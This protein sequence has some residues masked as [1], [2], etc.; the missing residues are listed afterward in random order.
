MSAG[1]F[2]ALALILWSALTLL[3]GEGHRNAAFALGA[4]CTGAFFAACRMSLGPEKMRHRFAILLVGL[5]TAN[6]AFVLLAN[7]PALL[8]GARILGWGITRQPI[9]G[10]SVMA[11][12]YLTA[13][14]LGLSGK[15]RYFGAAAI[16]GAFILAMQS[17]G[18]LVG[19]AGGTLVLL[20]AQP[21]R[22]RA[23]GSIAAMAGLCTLLPYRWRQQGQ[24]MLFARGSSHR[25]EIWAQS[26][27]QIRERPLFGHGLAA[28]LPPAPTGFPH[29]LYLS[30]LFYSGA[31]G[32]LLFAGLAAIVTIRI[33]RGMAEADRAWVAAL[34]ANALLAGLTD[35][36]QI[37]KGP[38]PLWFILW[39]P[40]ALALSAPVHATRS[41]PTRGIPTHGIPTRSRRDPSCASHDTA[42]ARWGE[43]A[44]ASD[45]K[46]GP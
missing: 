14:S 8:G 23:L 44:S 10:G 4:I 42:A 11:T 19:A 29:S 20:A 43:S 38:G 12:A 39:V 25:L 35:F 17:R 15:K 3:W 30:L 36:G 18:A 32:L 33:V 22:W 16:A 27:A 21:R 34:W 1:D 31:V 28:N 46:S 13:L 26:W 9:L 40:I 5:G 2:L 37:T 45:Q 41:R 24:N 6:A 7:M